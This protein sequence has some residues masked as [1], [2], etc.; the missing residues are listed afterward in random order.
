LYEQEEDIDDGQGKAGPSKPAQVKDKDDGARA[1]GSHAAV[2]KTIG[3]K[4]QV[5]HIEAPGI[6]Y[7]QDQDFEPQQPVTIL[8]DEA[9]E[10]EQDD[11]HVDHEGLV[12][13]GN[14]VDTPDLVNYVI[15]DPEEL[16]GENTLEVDIE[17]AKIPEASPAK[18]AS[19]WSKRCAGDTYE[20]SLKCATKVTK[21]LAPY[22]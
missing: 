6:T 16:E 19:R 13:N 1:N 14:S 3:T 12:D 20:D 15:K 4:R 10:M 21:H 5:F 7:L 17:V 11:E 8:A 9:Q 18:L 2:D 22:V